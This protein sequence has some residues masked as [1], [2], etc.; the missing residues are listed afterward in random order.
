M[1][2]SMEYP[3][4]AGCEA[5]ANDTYLV[6]IRAVTTAWGPAKHLHVQ[7]HDTKRVHNW[8][9]LQ[10]VKNVL[11]GPE[12]VAVEMYPAEADVV[13]ECHHYH[14][15]VLPEGLRLPFNLAEMGHGQNR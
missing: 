11:C 13:D 7:R 8:R 1:P 12:A 9:A 6:L 5:Y 4:L 3:A 2:D 15:W 10:E 14:L